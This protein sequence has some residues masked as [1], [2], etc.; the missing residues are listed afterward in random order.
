MPAGPY[1]LLA[2]SDTGVGMDDATAGPHLR[3]V[4]HHQGARQGHR[5]RAG[6]RVRHRQAERR[7]RL[8]STASSGAA[9]RSR[10]YLPRVDGASRSTP[11][12]E[13][14]ALPLP[15]GAETVLVVEDEAGCATLL[16]A[17]PRAARLHGARGRQ[18]RRG[19]R[20]RRRSY[21]GPIAPAGDRR[22]D[23]GHERARA[24]RADRRGPAGRCGCCTCRATPTTPSSATA[25]WRRA[26]R[27]SEAVHAARGGVARAVD[28]RRSQDR[29]GPPAAVELAP[30]RP[31]ALSVTSFCREIRK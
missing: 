26:S 19:A 3:A 20:D 11:R 30:S 24:G 22:R 31:L 23:A 7:P 10:V 6:D 1:V 9:R 29:A 4:L 13:P 17:D 25:C 8:W 15:R 14:A 28:P 16:A 27:C 21:G 12:H 5:P 18:R 2:V